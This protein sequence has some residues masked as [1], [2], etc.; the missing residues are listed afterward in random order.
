MPA[1]NDQTM[2]PLQRFFGLLQPDKKDITYV[3]LYAIFSGLITLSLPLGVQAIIG[4]IAGGNLSASLFLLVGIVT[5]GTAFSSILKVMQLTVM[6][7]IQRRIFARSAF[8]FTYRL[9][10]MRLNKLDAYFPPELVNRFFDTVT[11]QKGLPKI[12]VEL[13]AAILQILF[14]LIL[15]AFYHP[16][17]VF[18]GGLLLLLIYLVI[19]Y[20]GPRGLQT[21]LQESNYKYEVA[22]WLEEQA[23]ALNTFKLAGNDT[24]ALHKTDQLVTRYLD[25][26]KKHFRVLLMQYGSIVGF[27]TLITAGLLLLG[28]YLVIENQINIG[29]F[30]AAEIVII[31]ILAAVEKL[32][33]NMEVIYDVLTGLEKL[34]KVIDLPLEENGHMAIPEAELQ[35]GLAISVKDLYFQFPDAKSPT[36]KGLDLEVK[37]GE[38]VLIAG[39]R[40][41]GRATIM[42]I[43]SGLYTEFSGKVAFNGFPLNNLDLERLRRHI[44]DYSIYEDIFKGSILENITLGRSDVQM[45]EV[46]SAAQQLEL[47]EFVAS[48][49][50]GYYT[51]LLPEGRNI[52]QHIRTRIMLARCILADPLLL[53]VEGF[54][55][56]MEKSERELV[57]NTLTKKERRWTMLAVSDDPVLARHCDR[58]LIM[59]DGH[60]VDAGSYKEMQRSKHFAAVFKL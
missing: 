35:Q 48:L 33:M 27:K 43:I 40:R 19:R 24:L 22:Y 38:K 44:G 37:P 41:S 14:G 60:I 36:L 11:L 2:R 12:I 15:I 1:T 8:D 9:P 30:V 23:R 18:F 56:G 17:F 49:P 54:F 3:Y 16:F 51:E 32:I 25:A 4:L 10:R 45:H 55:S 42:R 5:A 57:I 34:G 20:T 50:K 39:Y 47:N 31:L 29:Q 26:R 52:P 53:T 6:E 58:I 28:G 59:Q 13:S 46:I 21:S 7:N